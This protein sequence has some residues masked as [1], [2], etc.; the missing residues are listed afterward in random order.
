MPSWKSHEP[1]AR[2]VVRV[3]PGAALL[4]RRAQPL[5]HRGGLVGLDHDLVARQ[6]RGGGQLLERALGGGVEA[7]QRDQRV[8]V[9][10]EP[11]R[12]GEPGR[13]DVEDAAAPR[14]V[15][16]RLDLGEPL[17]AHEDEPL[18]ERARVVVVPHV[19][20][21][22]GARQALRPRH[23]LQ[24]A[25]HRGEHHARPG[26]ARQPLPGEAAQRLEALGGDA[27]VRRGRVVGERVRLGQGERRARTAEVLEVVAGL[28]EGVAVADHVEHR[29]AARPLEP[30]REVAAGR[31]REPAQPHAGAPARTIVEQFRRLGDAPGEPRDALGQ[32]VPQEGLGGRWRWRVLSLQACSPGSSAMPK[33]RHRDLPGGS[34]PRSRWRSTPGGRDLRQPSSGRRGPQADAGPAWAALRRMPAGAPVNRFPRARHREMRALGHRGRTGYNSAQRH[35]GNRDAPAPTGPAD[36][37]G[38]RPYV[39]PSRAVRSCFCWSAVAGMASAG[40]ADGRRPP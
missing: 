31:A 40:D 16:D 23:L 32:L 4:A 26:S 20:L 30:G 35:V 38:G 33:T 29:A 24:H 17:V 21:E 10:L 22:Q 25:A 2:G 12:V 18:H 7:P 9:E 3:R 6:H 37:G 8:A 11:Q 19:Q 34:R 15:P 27:R 1:R 5:G 39:H 36:H 14:E 13:V 28:L